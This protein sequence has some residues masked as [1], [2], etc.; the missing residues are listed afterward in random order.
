MFCYLFL[1]VLEPIQFVS[2][3]DLHRH[4]DQIQARTL[5]HRLLPFKR[6]SSS[7][8]LS[9]VSIGTF[10]QCAVRFYFRFGGLP[11]RRCTEACVILTCLRH[12]HT[13][14]CF[15]RLLAIPPFLLLVVVRGYF[16]SIPFS[17]CVRVCFWCVFSHKTH[18]H[19]TPH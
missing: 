5:T 11:L 14:T 12:T 17:L 6:S 16:N 13:Y 18:T 3:F 2:S 8:A 9:L 15:A 7:P 10:Q 4:Q 1:V 19:T